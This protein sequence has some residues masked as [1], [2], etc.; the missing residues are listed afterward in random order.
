[1]D[2]K[3]KER[4]FTE[5]KRDGI[6]RRGQSAFGERG[7]VHRK[8]VKKNTNTSPLFNLASLVHTVS[9]DILV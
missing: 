4:P 7:T 1:M 9:P 5:E 6:E 8:W 2:I 3:L